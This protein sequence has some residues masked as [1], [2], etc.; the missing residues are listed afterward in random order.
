MPVPK[1]SIPNKMDMKPILDSE[2]IR[3]QIK[4]HENTRNLLLLSFLFFRY[5]WLFFLI[6]GEFACNQDKSSFFIYN[7][8]IN[9]SLLFCGHIANGYYIQ[10]V[11]LFRPTN[12]CFQGAI[13]QLPWFFPPSFF[14]LPLPF[15]SSSKPPQTLNQKKQESATMWGDPS[16]VKK[17]IY[18]LNVQSF[19]RF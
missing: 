11:A 15:S 9:K 4:A 16:K 18:S 3:I 8:Y 2:E 10:F 5:S 13:L 12:I 19:F 1:A 7:I 6:L 14:L 17:W